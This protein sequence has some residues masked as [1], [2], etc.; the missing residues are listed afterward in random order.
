MKNK[1]LIIYRKHI[2]YY[3]WH[4]KWNYKFIITDNNDEPYT[5]GENYAIQEKVKDKWK[6]LNANINF[7][8][9]A[10]AYVLDKNN[11]LRQNINWI[12]IYGNLPKGTYRIEKEAD[13]DKFY[14]N[15]F[16]IK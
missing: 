16:V 6:T 4:I 3:L 8:S 10:Y 1:N 9:N 12:N 15:E 2:K 14:S 11:Q 13:G 5:W 7:N